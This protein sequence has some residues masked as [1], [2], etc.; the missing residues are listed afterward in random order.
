MQD[1]HLLSAQ[2]DSTRIR[3][4]ALRILFAEV[5]DFLRI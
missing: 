1:G 5:S 3:F 4:F 2:L